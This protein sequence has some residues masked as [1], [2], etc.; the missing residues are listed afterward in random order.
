M[1]LLTPVATPLLLAELPKTTFGQ[2]GSPVCVL[3]RLL[4]ALFTLAVLLLSIEDSEVAF[5]V[6]ATIGVVEA[7]L[8]VVAV[9]LPG[10]VEVAVVELLVVVEVVVVEEVSLAAV[11]DGG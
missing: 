5:G 10:A 9:T 8:K 2:G 6:G 3:L 7:V 1:E 11:E 4:P